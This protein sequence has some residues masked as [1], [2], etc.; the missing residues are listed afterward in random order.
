MNKSPN[1][2]SKRGIW[3]KSELFTLIE[4]LVVIGIITILAALLLPALNKA[5]VT[6]KRIACT[7]NLKQI[8]AAASLYAND[9]NDYLPIGYSTVSNVRNWGYMLNYYLQPTGPN[10]SHTLNINVGYNNTFVCPEESTWLFRMRAGGCG[11]YGWNWQCGFSDSFT[12]YLGYWKLTK[13]KKSIAIIWDK[14]VYDSYPI[15]NLQDMVISQCAEIE[16]ASPSSFDTTYKYGSSSNLRMS[17]RHNGGSNFCFTDGHVNPYKPI[18]MLTRNQ[19][20]IPNY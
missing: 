7:S 19:L 6:A 20:F 13:I 9:N 10:Y 16:Q 14:N 4:L 17:I 5:R 8:G 3:L 18:E 11:G 1:S 15:V 12:N 2:R